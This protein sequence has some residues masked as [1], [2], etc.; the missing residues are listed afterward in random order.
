MTWVLWR[1]FMY[2]DGGLMGAIVSTAIALDAF[3]DLRNLNI[4]GVL[5]STS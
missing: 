2:F 5:T 1:L 3:F 4:V